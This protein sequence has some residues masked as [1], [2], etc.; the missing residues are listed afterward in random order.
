MK[1]KKKILGLVIAS[2]IT[3]IP[4]AGVVSCSKSSKSKKPE[5]PLKPT[6]PTPKVAAGKQ[7]LLT[8]YGYASS[9]YSATI[10]AI[11]YRIDPT[12][13]ALRMQKIK[14]DFS[15]MKSNNL[16][17]YN[18]SFR[19]NNS[20]RENPKWFNFSVLLNMDTHQQTYPEFGPAFSYKFGDPSTSGSINLVKWLQ[21]EKP[22][23]NFTNLASLYKRIYNQ[24]NMDSSMVPTSIPAISPNPAF[25]WTIKPGSTGFR[26][27]Y[28]YGNYSYFRTTITYHIETHDTYVGYDLSA[29]YNI[30]TGITT[31]PELFSIPK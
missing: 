29:V 23:W 19:V 6:I 12:Y 18:V 2:T 27:I 3:L 7:Y 26:P 1:Y 16:A 25:P 9:N 30:K 15:D 20:K 4:M 13:A 5:T 21:G 17:K 14:I 28:E 31:F 8:Y 11:I 24:K 22:N 10:E